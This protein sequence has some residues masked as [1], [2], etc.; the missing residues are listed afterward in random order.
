MHSLVPLAVEIATKT[1]NVKETLF[2]DLITALETFHQLEVT[3]LQEQIVVEVHI[4]YKKYC[5]RRLSK[6]FYQAHIFQF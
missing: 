4:D 1:L 3:G 5:M 6:K 2:A